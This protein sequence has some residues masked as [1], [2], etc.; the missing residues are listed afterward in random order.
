MGGIFLRSNLLKHY[1][2]ILIF[3]LV[4]LV[5]LVSTAQYA[6]YVFN[7]ID[8][9]SNGSVSFEVIFKLTLSFMYIF[10]MIRIMHVS[11]AK[12]KKILNFYDKMSN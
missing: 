12:K 3:F 1:R 4:F 10:I 9:D 2:M 7:A 8:R 6:H 5:I 11:Q